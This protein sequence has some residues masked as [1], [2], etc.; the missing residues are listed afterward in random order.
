MRCAPSSKPAQLARAGYTIIVGPGTY[1]ERRDPGD[2]WCVAA[3]GV[4]FIA[5]AT[6]AQTGDRSRPR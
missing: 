2:R 3:D 5:D 6:G 1:R 4:Q